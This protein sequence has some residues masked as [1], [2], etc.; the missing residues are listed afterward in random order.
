VREWTAAS[1]NEKNE[2][3]KN[4]HH[5]KSVKRSSNAQNV[6]KI[7]CVKIFRGASRTVLKVPAGTGT[8][9]TDYSFVARYLEN[10]HRT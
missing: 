2:K 9:G 1:K 8:T 6:D 7:L 3:M 10:K 5:Q 4:E